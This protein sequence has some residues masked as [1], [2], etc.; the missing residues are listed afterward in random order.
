MNISKIRVEVWKRSVRFLLFIQSAT[1][2]GTTVELHTPSM[3][4]EENGRC[5]NMVN[6]VRRCSPLAGFTQ[7][8][9]ILHYLSFNFPD[10]QNDL[11]IWQT[12]HVQLVTNQKKW[13]ITVVSVHTYFSHEGKQN[14]SSLLTLSERTNEHIWWS[15][16]WTIEPYRRSDIRQV[17]K[18]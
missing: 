1:H 16:C 5:V 9:M 11:L 4:S 10:L 3:M 13:S 7:N 12:S 17:W 8:Q 14:K 2:S 6:S 15:E 18:L